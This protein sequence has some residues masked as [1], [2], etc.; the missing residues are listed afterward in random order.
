MGEYGEPHC[1]DIQ[2]TNQSIRTTDSDDECQECR[3]DANVSYYN[4]RDQI[5]TI[6]NNSLS[7]F[8]IETSFEENI[9]YE[10][11]SLYHSLTF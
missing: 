4:D 9:E 6:P 11:N 1:V 8:S 5:T 3:Y 10:E 7:E 2:T